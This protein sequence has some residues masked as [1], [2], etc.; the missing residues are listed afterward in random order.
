MPNS[1]RRRFQ[2]EEPETKLWIEGF[3]AGDVFFDV[4]A[5]VGCF[6]LLA[7]GQPNKGHTAVAFEPSLTSFRSLCWNVQINIL[8]DRIIPIDAGLS[9]TT[10]IDRFN[11]SRLDPG[12]GE[13]CCGEPD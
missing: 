4:G 3:R 6:S 2:K 12:D 1:S 13:N 7:A 11:F 10:G 9:D 8:V 5:N